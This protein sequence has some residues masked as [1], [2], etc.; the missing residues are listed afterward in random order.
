MVKN[1]F[2]ASLVF[3][4]G[5]VFGATNV[6]S[7]A[8]DG[9]ATGTAAKLKKY[10]FDGFTIGIPESFQQRQTTT[11]VGAWLTPVV[12]FYGTTDQFNNENRIYVQGAGPF[13]I[14]AMDSVATCTRYTESFVKNNPPYW[15]TDLLEV[16]VDRYS[17]AF[18]RCYFRYVTTRPKYKLVYEH[19]VYLPPHEVAKPV[20]YDVFMYYHEATSDHEIAAM[21]ESIRSFQVK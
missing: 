7:Q 19:F 18:N 6:Q 15:S 13:A 2:I 14:R 5:T 16:K 3:W 12:I 8:L 4:V 11:K 21:R 10:S 17:P 9:V 20:Q 1:T